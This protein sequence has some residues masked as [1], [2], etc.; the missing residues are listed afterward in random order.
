MLN[1][2][3]LLTIY[4]LV[5]NSSIFL[6]IELRTVALKPKNIATRHLRCPFFLLI[7]YKL[8]HFQ[9]S[10]Y[11]PAPRTEPAHIYPQWSKWNHL[12]VLF[13]VKTIT[14]Y[15]LHDVH[16][17]VAFRKSVS[18]V[19]RD[20]SSI[21]RWLTFCFKYGYFIVYTYIHI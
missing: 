20:W 15:L 8:L 1:N 5:D 17:G 2:H 7:V 11:L 6:G 18:I 4:F 19:T 16:G 13:R 9:T 10:H 3:N 14:I 12:K 21:F